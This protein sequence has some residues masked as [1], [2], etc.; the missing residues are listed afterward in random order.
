MQALHEFYN[1]NVRRIFKCIQE[2]FIVSFIL[3]VLIFISLDSVTYEHILETW[4]V[5]VNL[6]G[7]FLFHHILTFFWSKAISAGHLQLFWCGSFV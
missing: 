6:D 1:A 2:Q 7:V 4:S 5:A 3:C